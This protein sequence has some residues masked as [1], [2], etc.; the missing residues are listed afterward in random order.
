MRKKVSKILKIALYVI[1]IVL[2]LGTVLSVLVNVPAVQ[3]MV[4][5]KGLKSMEKVLGTKVEVGHIEW[6]FPNRFVLDDINIWDKAGDSLFHIKRLETNIL[7]IDR[8]N[9]DVVLGELLINEPHVNFYSNG[10]PHELNYLFLTELGGEPTGGPPMHIQVKKIILNNGTFDYDLRA[11]DAPTDRR[12]NENHLRFEKI[13]TE[14]LSMSI[15]EDSLDFKV[16]KM[17][18]KEHS[19]LELKHLACKAKIHWYGMEFSEMLFRTPNS[20]IEH[21]LAFDYDGYP[22]LSDFIDSVQV[23]AELENT[24]IGFEDLALFSDEL[25]PY[26]ENTFDLEGSASGLVSN[27]KIK[28]LKLS[29]RNNT[30]LEGDLRMKGLPNVNTTYVDL[31]I[32]DATTFATDI[33]SLIQRELPE[34]IHK[35]GKMRFRGFATGFLNDFALDGSAQ[36]ALGLL[37]A[38]V[39]ITTDEKDMLHF[40]GKVD[41]QTFDIGKLLGTEELGT[42][43]FKIALD[44]ASGSNRS[45]LQ[46]DVTSTVDRIVIRGTEVKNIDAEG[47]FTSGSFEGSAKC[48][49]Q[50]AKFTF[51]GT[52]DFTGALSKYKF[53]SSIERFDLLAFKLDSVKS[54]ASANV[55]VNLVGNHIDQIN[56]M[57]SATDLRILR[58]GESYGINNLF[59]SSGYKNDERSIILRTDFADVDLKGNFLFSELNRVYADFLETLFPDYYEVKYPMKKPVVIT[60]NAKIRQSDLLD[61]IMPYGVEL[62]NGTFVGEYHSAE[63]SLAIDGR[64]DEIARGS[65]VLKDYFLNIRKKPHQLLNMTTDV[66]SVLQNDSSIAHSV[67]LNASILPNDVD[68]LLNVSDTSDA[69]ALRSFGLLHLGD[70]TIQLRLEQSHLYSYGRRWD[71]NDKNNFFFTNGQSVIEIL[72]LSSQ[73][74]TAYLTGRI[75]SEKD[76]KIS[77]WLNQFQLSNINPIIASQ[78]VQ[79][80]GF[81]NGTID[82]HQVLDRPLLKANFRVQDL[83]F[84]GDT[85]GNFKIISTSNEH[86]LVMNID[87]SIEEGIF[88]NLRT[89]GR[90]DWRTQHNNF[91]LDLV[92][93]QGSVK[94]F[95]NIFSGLASNFR[96]VVNARMKLKGSFDDPDLSGFMDMKNVAFKVD[97]LNT[98]FILN[99]RVSISERSIDVSKVNIKDPEGHTAKAKGSI[100]HD[101]FDDFVLDLSVVE[102]KSILAMNTTK[103]DNDLFYGKA[104]GTGY[105]EFKGPLDDIYLKIN[106]ESNKGT[107]LYIPV[108]SDN[109]NA[110]VEYVS[111]V[112]QS[113]KVVKRATRDIEGITMDMIFKVNEDAEFELLFDEL[114]DDKIYG[115]GFGSV[116]IEMNTYGDFF[117]FGDFEVTEGY[118]P[119]S[120]PMLVSERFTLKKGSKI[121]WDGDPYNAYI[122]MEASIRRNKAKPYHLMLGSGF[123]SDQ[124]KY[125]GEIPVDVL[126]FLRGELFNPEISFG[127]DLPESASISGGSEF[128]SILNRVRKDEDE[129][130][131]QVFSLVTFGSFSPTNFYNYQSEGFNANNISQTVNNN[132]SSFLSGQ[133][134]NW[135]SQYN[136]NWEFGFDWQPENAEQNAE[137][138]LSVRRKL[139]NDRLEIAGSVDAY[140]NNGRNPY[141][142]NLVY[143]VKED[144][145]I[146]VKAFQKLANDPTLGAINNITT[147]GV[148]FFF[149][150]QFDRIR[151]RRK[152]PDVSQN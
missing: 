144:G 86:P 121:R 46:G 68:F 27:F 90:V 37:T 97:Y 7:K 25:R 50:K 94:P 14:I 78:D 45:D 113:N 102:A 18:T 38:N 98:D 77:I 32:D 88:K 56:G 54:I 103:E 73:G 35:F 131:R 148:G 106:A 20:S 52:M 110:L 41:G 80:Y 117:M 47:H 95:E 96:G 76:Q 66:S 2:A 143:N 128:L 33:E 152:E 139:F 151:F 85:L 4:L 87:A 60:A 105:I 61:L 81:A 149:R 79:V 17:S 129:L 93:N 120:S 130:N 133:I 115:R 127:I 6:S 70:D 59:A 36:S 16:K 31:D 145:K 123:I 89:Y 84:N 49:D 21:Y 1:L 30:S 51:N 8:K 109:E 91:D 24:S 26:I 107:K 82:V 44:N 100:K 118:Y 136:Q 71:I 125:Q 147:T 62:G 124:S 150:T 12:F 65:Y 135:L 72:E 138:I 132:L 104:Y 111:F 23:K 34:E 39:H 63:K 22:V 69:I 48:D 119:F 122:D 141:N 67:V 40:D 9:G 3:Q 57:L 74:E 58:H 64:M 29:N 114:L 15:L 13:N 142:L 10:K 101:L 55:D 42:S 137:L 108:Y 43:D 75:G 28:D 146:R 140:T 126:L 99:D 83:V 92:L 112:D 19:G 53:T 5:R 116:K 11:Y 134:N